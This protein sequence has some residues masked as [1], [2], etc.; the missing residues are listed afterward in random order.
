MHQAC[1]VLLT[2]S[3]VLVNGQ[4]VF[5]D[6]RRNKLWWPF[7]SDSLWNTAI[8]GSAQ[9]IES[10]L[11]GSNVFKFDEDWFV[12]TDSNDPVVEWKLPFSWNHR[13]NNGT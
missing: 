13:C 2:T 1:L 6:G 3:L 11:Q 12:I 7:A 9:Y 4:H 10:G 5:P 8:G